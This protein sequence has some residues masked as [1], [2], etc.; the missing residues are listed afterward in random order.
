MLG[1]DQELGR[2]AGTEN[3]A[4]IVGM[5]KASQ[6]AGVH[7]QEVQ[8][9]VG[10][11]RDWLEGELLAKIADLRITGWGRPRLPNTAHLLISGVET[12]ALLMKLDL[13]GFCCSSGSAC[14]SGA[15]EKSHVVTAMGLGDG[16]RNGV[17]RISLSRLTRDSDVESLVQQ[18]PII[19]DML[20]R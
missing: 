13:A 7:I 15:P 11:M 18:L 17:L 6:L 16:K 19:V 20:R 9:R 3:V 4:A 10:A 2:R 5:G 12:E 8:A 14:Q 1:G